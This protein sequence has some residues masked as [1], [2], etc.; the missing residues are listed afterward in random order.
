MGI[1]ER[2]CEF[3]IENNVENEKMNKDEENL[4]KYFL[5]KIFIIF[6]M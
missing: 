2:D 3:T 6:M 4:F 1:V 5:V